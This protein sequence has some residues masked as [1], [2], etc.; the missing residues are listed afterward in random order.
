MK[1]MHKVVKLFMLSLSVGFFTA[2]ADYLDVVPDG[3]ATIDNAFSNRI[4]SEKFL[5][6]CYNMLPNQNDP[7][8]YPGRRHGGK[9]TGDSC[10][11]RNVFLCCFIPPPHGFTFGH[12]ACISDDFRQPGR[13]PGIAG[14]EICRSI[15]DTYHAAVDHHNRDYQYRRFL[16]PEQCNACRTGETIFPPLLHAP[17]VAGTGYSGRCILW[18]NYGI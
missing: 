12:F 3:V 13:T 15:A 18:G 7:W 11:R 14:D 2:C 9:G 16:F 8:N 10:A 6:S 5:F 4:N 17:E 1:Q